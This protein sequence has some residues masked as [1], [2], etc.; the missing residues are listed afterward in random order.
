MN[1]K[2]FSLFLF[3]IRLTATLSFRKFRFV[4]FAK[5]Q[6]SYPNARVIVRLHE[7]KFSVDGRQ[8]LDTQEPAGV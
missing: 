2:N 1:W 4:N 3:Y 7:I 8:V 6:G 5:W